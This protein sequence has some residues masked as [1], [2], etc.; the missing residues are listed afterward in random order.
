METLELGFEIVRKRK[1]M[2]PHLLKEYLGVGCVKNW[3]Q[4]MEK[5]L[6]LLGLMYK[7]HKNFI[8]E[9]YGVTPYL[10]PLL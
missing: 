1:I 2:M 3:Y 9:I 4:S 8:R 5:T 6:V 7:S 10:T